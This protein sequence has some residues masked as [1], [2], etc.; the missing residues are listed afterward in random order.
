[1][2]THD[3]CIILAGG[4]GR[5]LWPASREQRPKQFI[6]F[7]GVGRTLLQLTYDRFADILPPQNI[8]VSTFADYED[9]V[10]Q[11]LPMLT[12]EQI[13]IEPVQLSTGPAAAWASCRPARQGGLHR[14]HTGRP[15]HHRRNHLCERDCRRTRLCTRKPPISGHQRQ[16]FHTYDGLRLHSERRSPL[17][18]P[19]SSEVFHRKAP[20]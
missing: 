17:R 15:T 8:Y 16:S 9:L 20:A 4:V 10:R 13:L 12:D 11:Q 7:F 1:M 5:R 14:D 2:R 19:L 3:Y 18:P 6:D